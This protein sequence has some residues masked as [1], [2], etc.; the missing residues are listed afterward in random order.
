MY[1]VRRGDDVPAE[2]REMPITEDSRLSSMEK[3]VRVVGP[4]DSEYLTVSTEVATIIKWLQSVSVSSFERVT[5][6]DDGVIVGCKATVPKGILK[7]QGSARKSN[8]HSQMVSY[9]DAKGNDNDVVEG[10]KRG[11]KD[12]EEGRTMSEDDLDEVLKDDG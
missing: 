8:T 3:E 7:F 4:K 10:I 5:V 1:E 11:I 6:N 2:V 9:G 12:I